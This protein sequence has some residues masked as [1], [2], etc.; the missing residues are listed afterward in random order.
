MAPMRL[1]VELLPRGPYADLALLVDVLRAST[2]I[3][4]LFEK[5]AREVWVTKSLR[6]ARELDA[7]LAL[8]EREG[9]PPEGFAHSTSP[10]EILGLDLVG[11]SVAYTSENL[12]LAIERAQDAKHV[13]LGAFVNA[14]AAVRA[15]RQLASEE[16]AIVAAGHRGGEALDDALASGFLAKKLSRALPSVQQ[17]DGA[18]IAAALLK[19]FPDPQEALWQSESGQLLH[20]RGFTEDLA[21]A[22]VIGRTKKVPRLAERRQV[23]DVGLFRFL[24]YEPD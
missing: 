12:P 20:A 21:H 24:P 10:V 14:P 6:L 1:R 17:N 11:K 7:D 4:L 23:R 15:A 13:L 16:I 2:S 22:S 9:L 3:A 8:G 5:G 19:A 18:R